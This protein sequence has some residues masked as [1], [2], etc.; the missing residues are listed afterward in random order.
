MIPPLP[1]DL[2]VL[3]F[4]L[5]LGQRDLCRCINELRE[6]GWVVP[7]TLFDV[8]HSG[9]HVLARWQVGHAEASITRWTNRL[10]A[11]RC[12]RPIRLVCREYDD[13]ELGRGLAC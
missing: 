8:G 10:N 13:E 7:L 4:L 3:H 2:Q 1:A 6:K 5:T 11:S 9:D 12:R